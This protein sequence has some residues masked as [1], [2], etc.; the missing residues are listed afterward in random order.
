M[1]TSEARE[2]QGMG[3]GVSWP[4]K[5]EPVSGPLAGVRVVEFAAIGPAP[6]AGM[7]L[8]DLGADVVRV[9]PPKGTGLGAD[10]LS[11]G[12]RAI[13]VDAKSNSGKAV[14][15]NLIDRADIVIEG[16]RPG[17]L[18]RLGFAPDVLRRRNPHLV[19]GRMTGWGQS[20]PLAD[21]PGHDINYVALS[22][23]LGAIGE[24]GGPPVV[25]LNLVGDFGGG[26]MLLVVGVLSAY[27][28]AFRT[29]KGQDV[30]AAMIDGVGL[31]ATMILAMVRDGTWKEERG[32]NL[33]DGG[34]PFYRTY[35]CADGAYIALG[36]LEPQFFAALIEVLGCAGE[37]AVKDQYDRGLWPEME[38]IFALRIEGRT[39]AEWVKL[40][41][42]TDA[43]LS[44]VL[45]LSERET[46]S[47][48][49]KRKSDVL[50]GGDR[51]PSPAP[52]FSE[53]EQLDSLPQ[54]YFAT[55]DI[56]SEVGYSI[57][58]IADLIAEGAV[59]VRG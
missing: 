56:L 26:G 34:A 44:P 15:R 25:P 28:E 19:V 23:V 46:S 9:D 5:I 18:E 52:R 14:I 16:Y 33:L 38:K 27:I 35:R 8:A 51:E 29:G 24:R 10:S 4:W 7:V 54:C 37:I 47:F 50:V 49:A 3:F 39:R 55:E 6:F 2:I 48:H 58:E 36:A 13:T 42:G 41:E 1:P 43:C 11:R 53:H 45:A 17:V 20:S 57:Q 22:G 31:L 32:G 12:K 40:A 30:D 21:K 59:A